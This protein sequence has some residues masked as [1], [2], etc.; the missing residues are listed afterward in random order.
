[1]PSNLPRLV[2]RVPEDIYN[3]FIN[4]CKLEERTAS[5]LLAVLVKNYVQ[6]YNYNIKKNNKPSQSSNSRTG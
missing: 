4:I 6:E 5:N 3:E 1:M 2:T